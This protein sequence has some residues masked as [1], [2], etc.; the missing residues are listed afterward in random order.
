MQDEA[1]EVELRDDEGGLRP[2]F[3]HAVVAALDADDAA[4]LRDLTLKLHAADLANLIEL[5][6]PE[7]R[8]ALIATLGEDF[9]AAALA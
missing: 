6:R 2:E 3:L 5:L 9:D 1:G 7:Q 4:R 8:R